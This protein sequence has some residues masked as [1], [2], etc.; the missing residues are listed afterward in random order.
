MSIAV[1]IKNGKLMHAGPFYN[2][3][4]NKAEN[5]KVTHYWP[6]VSGI[7]CSPVDSFTD[8]H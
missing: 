3:M 1:A 6:L 8:G 7:H 4:S 2:D 5:I